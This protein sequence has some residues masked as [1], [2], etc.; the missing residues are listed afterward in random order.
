MKKPKVQGC[1]PWGFT[2]GA[3]LFFKPRHKPD[4]LLE[5]RTG[6]QAVMGTEG[7]D[8]CNT[9]SNHIIEV[10]QVLGIEA[11]RKCIIE[12]IKYTMESHGMSID[13][14]H[15]ML[16]GDLMTFR[17][18]VLGITRFGI[19]KMDKSVLMLA[20][21]EKTADH[22]FNASVNGRDDKIEGVSECV[23]MGIPMPLG[24]GMLKV[25]QR[26]SVPQQ[27]PYGPPAILS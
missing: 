6:L 11:A 23:I 4:L 22:L 18:E 24:T 2:K 12:E 1:E 10:Q 21:F 19:Q 3:S 27:L 26:V 15:M 14:R 7:V 25:R 16:L 5:P 17:G 9:K 8:G 13:I 20:S